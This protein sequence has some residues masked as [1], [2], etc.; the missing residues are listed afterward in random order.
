MRIIAFHKPV[1]H[2][3]LLDSI[4][5]LDGVVVQGEQIFWKIVGDGLQR[6]QFS[7]HR[8]LIPYAER[9][10]IVCLVFTNDYHE[11]YFC[12]TG[13]AYIDFSASSC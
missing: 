4:M 5:K 11:V 3:F 1:E 12:I 7:L 8:G 10:L 13:F 6:C 9:Y 2:I